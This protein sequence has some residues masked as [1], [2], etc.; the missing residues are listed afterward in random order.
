[1]LLRDAEK[2]KQKIHE[3]VDKAVDSMIKIGTVNYFE[4]N[5]KHVNGEILCKPSYTEK[6]KI[7]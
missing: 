7:K 1:M 2:L 4:I 6:E 5:I 3:R